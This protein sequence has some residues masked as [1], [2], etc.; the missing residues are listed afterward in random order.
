MDQE[1]SNAKYNFKQ[2]E[3]EVNKL[4][5]ERQVYRECKAKTKNGPTFFFLDG[6]PY[7]S[8]TCYKHLERYSC[9]GKVHVGT[10]RNKTM[11]DAVLRFKRMNGF[12]VMDRPGFVRRIFLFKFFLI[13][14]GQDMHGGGGVFLRKKR[15][16]GNYN[17]TTAKTSKNSVWKNSSENVGLRA[18]KT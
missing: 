18:W 3:N 6:P 12:N 10:A 16:R 5:E 2:V 8:G 14:F 17:Y 15:R 9:V 11:K 7:T 1:T 13:F 4:W